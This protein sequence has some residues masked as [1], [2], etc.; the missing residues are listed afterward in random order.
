MEKVIYMP[1]IDE[2]TECWRPVRANLIDSDIFQ[3]VDDIPR[4]ES[5]AF[6]P[7][8][9]VRCRDKVLAD[10]RIEQVI[11]AYAIESQPYY[12]L[13]KDHE[14]EVFRI[15][16]DTEEAVVK[17]LHVD[18]EHEDFTCDVLSTNSQHKYL[19]M[20]KAVYTINFASLISAR[21][22]QRFS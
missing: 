13:F 21:L 20:Q 10:G 5:W 9:R 3:V 14:G 22:E 2:G 7:F 6:A 16:T 19:N 11:F 17:V 1:L 15:V 8:S 12:R 18:E 4:G